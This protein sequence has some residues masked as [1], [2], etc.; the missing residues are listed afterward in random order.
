MSTTE[1]NDPDGSVTIDEQTF[2]NIRAEINAL[3]VVYASLPDLPATHRMR[4]ILYRLRKN[5]GI[6]PATNQPF[7]QRTTQ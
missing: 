7:T 2:A 1:Q 3:G 5:L 6:D 4:R